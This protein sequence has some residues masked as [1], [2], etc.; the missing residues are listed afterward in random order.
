MP[1]LNDIPSE[2]KVEIRAERNYCGQDVR[3]PAKISVVVS[4]EEKTDWTVKV[5]LII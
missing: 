2:R 1:E 3:L 4:R 5:I